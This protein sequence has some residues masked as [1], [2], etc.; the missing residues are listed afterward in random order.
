MLAAVL[1]LSVFLAASAAA[2][3]LADARLQSKPKALRIVVIEGE[4]AVNIIQQ[5]TAV[6]PLIEVRDENDLPVAGVVVTFSTQSAPTAV[7]SGGVRTL[8]VT[9]NAAGRAFATGFTPLSAGPVEISVSASFQGQVASATITQTNIAGA[10]AQAATATGSGTSGGGGA[11]AGSGAIS[12]GVVVGIVAAG[13]VAGGIAVAAGGGQE[14]AAPQGSSLPAT[15]RGSFALAGTGN[16]EAGCVIDEQYTVTNAE[17]SL[18]RLGSGTATIPVSF[19][20]ISRTPAICGNGSASTSYTFPITLS[21]NTYSSRLQFPLVVAPDGTVTGG[22][23]AVLSGEV[24]RDAVV[25]TLFFQRDGGRAGTG[26]TQ[27]SYSL[28]RVR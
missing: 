12:K 24:Q 4:D 14:A 26:T 6:A 3:P 15:F 25:G 28:P 19:V 21:G 23:T 20:F 1:S 22:F 7:F 9:T 11:G 18:D 2:S 17:V 5:K 8:T 13:A 16:F 27:G 10:S